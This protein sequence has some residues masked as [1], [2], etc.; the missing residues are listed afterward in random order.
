MPKFAIAFKTAD[1]PFIHQ[2]VETETKDIALRYFF[3]E[4]APTGSYT[5]DEEGY[6]YFHDDFLDPDQPQGSILAL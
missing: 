1:G 2:V 4:F 6:S 5:K 3:N